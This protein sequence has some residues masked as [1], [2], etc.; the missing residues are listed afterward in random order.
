MYSLNVIIKAN[1]EYAAKHV[2]RKQSLGNLS[3]AYKAKAYVDWRR[4][5]RNVPY[6][7]AIAMLEK[8]FPLSHE[9]LNEVRSA[10]EE[11]INAHHKQLLKTIAKLD[12]A[13]AFLTY[14]QIQVLT[15]L[16]EEIF[17]YLIEKKW[18]GESR[19]QVKKLYS[20]VISSSTKPT[21]TLPYKSFQ[22]RAK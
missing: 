2:G 17:S 3:H 19:G 7:K 11:P 12:K 10:Q 20:I 1:L 14:Q 5:Q 4:K 16:Q 9:K 15:S 21:F 22:R 18:D 6:Q 13:L 8:F